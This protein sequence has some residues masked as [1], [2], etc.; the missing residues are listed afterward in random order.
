MD[1][2]EHATN[3]RRAMAQA[4][5]NNNDV[6]T[7][8]GVSVRTVVNWISRSQPTMPSDRDQAGLA[9]LLPGYADGGDPV[10]VAIA[11]ADLAPYRRSELLA[12][13][14]RLLHEQGLEDKRSG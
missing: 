8:L 13:Y 9:R 14:Q 11:R 7:A 6:A 1:R 4:G 12:M 10:E 3:L 2:T 5:L